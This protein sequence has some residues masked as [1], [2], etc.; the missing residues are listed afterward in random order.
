MLWLIVILL[1]GSLSIVLFH[2]PHVN[3]MG[4]GWVPPEQRKPVA[5]R[6][7]RS[8]SAVAGVGPSADSASA[9][10]IASAEGLADW[11]AEDAV[12]TPVPKVVPQMPDTFD[13]NDLFGGRDV[14]PTDRPNA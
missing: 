11:D 9:A 7:A 6:P 2:K 5:S 10:E 8:T 12:T 3:P 4:A 14:P 1:I 13:F